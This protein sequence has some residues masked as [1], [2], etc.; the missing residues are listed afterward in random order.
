MRDGVEPR[1]PGEQGRGRGQAR[2]MRKEA[3][4]RSLRGAFLFHFPHLWLVS[5]SL[6]FS[7]LVPTVPGTRQARCHLREFSLAVPSPDTVHLP[8]VLQVFA[9]T[10]WSSSSKV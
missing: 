5:S 4:G 8:H 1:H 7:L 9:V 6:L 2:R 3:K 10:S